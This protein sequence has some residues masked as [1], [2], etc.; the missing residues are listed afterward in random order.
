VASGLTG[1]TLAGATTLAGGITNI[2]ASSNFATNI[3]TGTTTSAVNI[4]GAANSIVLGATKGITVQANGH[5]NSV[6][7]VIPT[8]GTCGTTPVIATGSTDVAG[9]MTAG[10]ALAGT[11]T[12]N[13][14]T[15]FTTAPFCSVTQV[16]GTATVFAAAP[17]TTTIVITGGVSS[18]KYSWVCIGL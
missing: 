17:T 9:A 3:G 5:L 13:F 2:N 15:A 16:T 12:I 18:A 8:I 6:T 10:S 1:L 14:G 4:G 11:C 7:S